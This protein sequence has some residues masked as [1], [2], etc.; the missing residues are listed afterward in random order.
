MRTLRRITATLRRWRSRDRAERE[1]HDEI[2]SYAALRAEELRADGVPDD[3]ARRRA[4]AELGGIESVKESVRE[5]RTGAVAEQVMQ[6]V[7]YALRSLARSP[8]FSAVAILV[9]ALGIGA[10]AAIFSLINAVLFRPLPVR[11]PQELVY[12]YR[13]SN[14]SYSGL[15]LDD[16]DRIA[17]RTDLFGALTGSTVDFARLRV[18]EGIEQVRGAAVVANY[19]DVLG[20]APV[21]GRSFAD[22]EG[23]MTATPS[24]VISHDLWMRQF[25]GAPGIIGTAID[26]GPGVGGYTTERSRSYT[27]IGIAPESFHGTGSPWEQTEYWVPLQ[28]R[29]ADYACADPTYLSRAPVV[30]IGRLAPGVKFGEAAAFVSTLSASNTPSR[31]GAKVATVLRPS[32][33][34]RLPFDALS[35]LPVSPL[36]AALMAVSGLVLII[37]AAN[38]IGLYMARSITRRADTAIRLTLGAGRGRIVRQWLIESLVLSLAGGLGGLALARALV[39]L[40]LVNLPSSFGARSYATRVSLEVPIDLRVLVFTAVVCLAAGLLIGV[41]PA[42]Q[43]SQTDVLSSLSGSAT[44]APRRDRSQMRRWILIPQVALS[45]TLLLVAGVLVR[46][47]LKQEWSSP[48]YTAEGVVSVE[49]QLPVAPRCQQSPAAYADLRSRRGALRAKLFAGLAQ[50][51]QLTSAALSNTVPLGT[52]RFVGAVVTPEGFAS[53]ALGS[54]RRRVTRLLPDTPDQPRARTPVHQHGCVRWPCGCDR[55]SIARR[56]V[57]AGR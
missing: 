1:L 51:S 3:E 44:S 52:I 39:Q 6:D 14:G 10:N 5:R 11:A 15:T 8:G 32:R 41:I 17:Q 16:Y 48:G 12:A 37:A 7:R 2:Q 4:L 53:G 13:A 54:A 27:I 43:A 46:A 49:Y 45:L 55:E 38:L 21:F 29:A 24:V 26:L 40:F 50:C 25:N 31:P 19:F 34:S 33:I 20:V 47:L 35:T 42:R 23:A 18:G 30:V 56:R 36:A 22:G 28:Q 57:V 9:L